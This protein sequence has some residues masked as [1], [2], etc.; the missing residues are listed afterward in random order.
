MVELIA[1]A[2]YVAFFMAII[3]EFFYMG[4]WKAPWSLLL[5]AAGYGALGDITLRQAPVFVIASAFLSIVIV[6][7]AE[8]LADV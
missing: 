3:I 5:S 6:T 4:I 7:W 2:L 1:V 8:K